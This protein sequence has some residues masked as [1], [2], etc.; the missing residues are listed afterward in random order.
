MTQHQAQMTSLMILLPP[1]G[2]PGVLIYAKAQG[3]LPWFVILGAVVGFDL[4][5][6]IGANIAT[7]MS[8][9]GL[10]RFYSLVLILMAGMMIW[11]IAMK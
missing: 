8:G 6:Y 4:G 2:L 1:I 7:R 9:A 11:K 10:K 5:S 3:G